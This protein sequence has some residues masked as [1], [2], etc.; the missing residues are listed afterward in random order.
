MVKQ[1]M[2][3]DSYNFVAGVCNKERTVF[4]MMP[5]PERNNRDFKPVLYKLLF[6]SD[7]QISTQLHFHQKVLELMQSEHISY[8]STRKYLKQLHTKEPWVIQ[9]PGENAGIVNIGDGL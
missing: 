1:L 9:G 8:K 7:M 4:G 3:F 6:P 5:H 2:K